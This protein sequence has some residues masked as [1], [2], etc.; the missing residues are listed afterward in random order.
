MSKK[1]ALIILDG[2]GITKDSPDRNSIVQAKTPTFD[3]L[4]SKSYAE[5]EAS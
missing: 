5:I 4:F 1:V 3:Y 2:F